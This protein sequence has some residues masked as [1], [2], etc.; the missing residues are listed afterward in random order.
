MSMP[1]YVQ[2]AL[3]RFNRLNIKGANSPIIYVP[4]KYGAFSQDVLPDN[5][6]PPLSDAQKLELQEIIG[7][8]LFYARAVDPLMITAVNKLGCVQAVATTQILEA[9]DRFMSYASRFPDTKLR[10]CASDMKLYGHGDASY[11]SEPKAR[12]R[13]GGYLFLGKCKPGD[14]PNA[15]INYFS[16]VISTVVASATEAEYAALFMTGQAAISIRN[17]LADLGYPQGTTEFIC[18]NKCAVGIANNTLKQKRSKT[19]DMRYHWIRD[20][21]AAKIFSITWQP[22]NINLADFFTKAHPV[23]HHLSMRKFY[24]VVDDDTPIASITRSEGVLDKYIHI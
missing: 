1:G 7:V 14:I 3:S 8:F 24:V 9:V 16:V 19:I 20:Q 10:I 11:L 5:P 13:A 17:T 2:K 22:G 12:S 23:H 18:D 21:V 15:A 4:P 6:Y